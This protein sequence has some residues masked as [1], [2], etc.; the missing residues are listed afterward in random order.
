MA[1]QVDVEEK[2]RFLKMAE[3]KE[4]FEAAIKQRRAAEF[5][6]LQVRCLH[7]STW[8]RAGRWFMRAAWL[9]HCLASDVMG[10][11]GR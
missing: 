11:A 1:S 2:R 10:D 7:L 6:A 8:N 3:D 4:V 5:A 9:R